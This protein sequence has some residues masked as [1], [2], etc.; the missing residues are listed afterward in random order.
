M[1]V[2]EETAV[3]IVG[4]GC[5]LPGGINDLNGLWQALEQGSDL[6]TEVPADRFDADRW[7]DEGGS[8][9]DRSYTRA[10]GFLEDVSRFDAA[11]FRISP[12]EAS[13]MDPQQRLLL[14]MAAEALDDAGIDPATLAGP[15][16]RS[17][18]ASP[19]P[20][21]ARSRCSGQAVNPYMMLGA[22][23]R[24]PPTG[25]RTRST[26]AGR[27]WRWTPRARRRCWR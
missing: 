25:C 18:S 19:T 22:T 8:F 11:Y 23:C 12:K 4:V 13:A 6:V 9:E 16:P 15:A 14:E 1:R 21:T 17:S 24:S 27:A 5:R 7:V 10:G 26:C 20:P 3:A 2:S